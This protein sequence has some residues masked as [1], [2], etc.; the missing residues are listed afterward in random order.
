MDLNFIVVLVALVLIGMDKQF[1]KSIGIEQYNG[2]SDFK[3][4]EKS[5]N[6]N[7]SC[8]LNMAHVTILRSNAK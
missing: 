4:F 2:V 3:D 7:L 5:F 8:I 1:A 6:F